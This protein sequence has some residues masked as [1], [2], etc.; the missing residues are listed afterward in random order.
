MCCESLVDCFEK[1][2]ECFTKLTRGRKLLSGSTVT[3]VVLNEKK[4][5][6]ANVGDSGAFLCRKSKPVS[7]Y[8]KHTP[9][10]EAEKARVTE[11]GGIGLFFCFLFFVIIILLLLLLFFF[12]FFF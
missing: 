4:L 1:T 12:F 11:N 10:D 9:E 2:D 6:S 3:A 5:F 7:L 8:K